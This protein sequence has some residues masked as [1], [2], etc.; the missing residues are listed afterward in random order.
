MATVDLIGIK[1][2]FPNGQTVIEGFDLSVKDGEF[3]VLLGPSGCGKTTLL[4]MIAG[5]E[6]ATAGRIEIDGKPVNDLPA[7][8]RNVAMVFQN[9]ALYPHMT[10]FDNMAFPLRFGGTKTDE[11]TIQKKVAETARILNIEEELNKKPAA[12]SGGQKQRVALGRAIV[13]DPAVF[14]FDEPLSNLD[15]DLRARMRR[16]LVE[17]GQRLGV[18]M[19]YVTHDQVEAMTMG[20]RIAVIKGGTLQQLAPPQDIYDH[21]QSKF[22]AGFIG[23]PRMNFIPAQL[24]KTADYTVLT[25]QDNSYKLNPQKAAQLANLPENI[26]LGIRPEDILLSFSQDPQTP[27]LQATLGATENMGHEYIVEMHTPQ[28][29]LLARTRTPPTTETTPFSFDL[30]KCHFFAE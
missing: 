19:I 7:G 3:L 24:T 4:R 9:Y 16:E 13:R 6:E 2:T 26:L 15:A 12:L 5:L 14:L 18:T 27:T 25:I 17:L 22:V 21:P 10:A 29:S 11:K 1:K 20:D 28:T 30:N 8:R 23:T